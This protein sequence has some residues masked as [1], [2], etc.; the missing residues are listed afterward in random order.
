MGTVPRATWRRL[1][2]AAFTLLLLL[3]AVAGAD[4][5]VGVTAGRIEVADRLKPGGAYRLPPVGVLNTGDEPGQYEVEAGQ[6]SAG[7]LKHAPA[8]WFEFEPRRFFLEPGGG[9]EVS[10]RLVLPASAEP[11][12]YAAYIEARPV[13]DGSGATIG[14][15]AATSLTFSVKPSSWLAAQRLR[16]N[17]W[18]DQLWPW[19]LVAPSLVLAGLGVRWLQENYQIVRRR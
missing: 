11:G 15:S 13:I 6:P 7:G 9:Q 17:R 1:F 3:P 18:M 19:S 12:D 5:G 2:A 14:V 8:S 10:V 4:R 16:V